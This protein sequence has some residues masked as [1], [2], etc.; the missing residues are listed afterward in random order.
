[1]ERPLSEIRRWKNRKYPTER[2]QRYQTSE[3]STKLDRATTKYMGKIYF[4]FLNKSKPV[5][6]VLSFKDKSRISQCHLCLSLNQCRGRLG[7]PHSLSSIF[8]LYTS[9]YQDSL[10]YTHFSCTHPSSISSSI[11]C[12]AHLSL[13]L[14]T[15]MWDLVLKNLLKRI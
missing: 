2:T 8:I 9:G 15:S 6:L 10:L 3:D 7:Y 14:N 4:L 5:I 11:Q 13:Y 12:G 1:M